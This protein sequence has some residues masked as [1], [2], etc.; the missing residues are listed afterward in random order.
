VY[1]QKV[2]VVVVVVLRVFCLHDSV[3]QLEFAKVLRRFGVDEK[4][5]AQVLRRFS[6][7]A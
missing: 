4:E 5:L 2:A 1:H 3:D 6:G 7:V